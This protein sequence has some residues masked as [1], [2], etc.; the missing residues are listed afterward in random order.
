[1]NR[2][3]SRRRVLQGTAVALVLAFD[4]VRR[5]WVTEARAAASGTLVGLPRLDGT[6][7][8]DATALQQA[9]DDFGHIEH[10]TPIAV[11]EP[12]SVED[13]A[14]I[15]RFA[16]THSLKVAMRGQGH[17]TF[18]QAQAQGGI[19]IN[20][21]ALAT[22]HAIQADRAVVDSGVQWVDLVN[23]TLPRGLTPPV[24]TD[25]LE[26]SVGGT[27]SLGGIG[28]A[29]SHFGAQV[30]NVLELEVVTGRG[31][32]KTCSRDRDRDLFDAVLAGLGQCAIIT[33]AT[34]RLVGA[35]TNA[36]VFD[37]F[38]ADIAAYVRDQRMLLADGRFD[39][40][41]G[42]VVPN[43]SGSGFMY[44]IEAATFFTPP[45]SPNAAALLA[46]LS[47]N[48]AARQSTTESFHDFA[49]RLEP[50]VAFL[51]SVGAWFLPHPFFSVFVPISTVERYVGDIVAGLT[52]ADTGGGPILFYPFRR[53]LLQQPLLRAPRE[54]FFTF[55]LLRFAPPN[56]PATVNAM[57]ASNLALYNAAVAAGGTQYPLGSI[58]VTPAAWR[59][60]Y[61]SSFDF[62]EDAKERFDPDD[63]LTPG[64]GIFPQPPP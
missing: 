36:V 56:D 62:L 42:Q 58:P 26:L 19:V 54:D 50:L 5:S 38:Y 18:G 6:L 52:T 64:Q 33:R 25:L 17:A 14:R 63:V 4:P 49:F 48:A 57:I 37:L 1:M 30:D 40:L 31:N 24:L 45:D 55:N 35:K 59:V 32:I 34:V 27:L 51:K 61:G 44:M 16:R 41:E 20:S 12:G 29:A 60:H 23:A 13:I 3:L 53:S 9:A 10:R 47:D 21:S 2:V 15:I 11:L 28:G 8:V 39:Y 7:R 43:S 22:I 46:G